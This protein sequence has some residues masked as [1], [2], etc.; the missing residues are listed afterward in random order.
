MKKLIFS[1]VVFS[2]LLIIGCQENFLTDPIQDTSMNDVQ[3]NSIPEYRQGTIVLKGVLANP[4][5]SM[6]EYYSL[7]GRISFKH[8]TVNNIQSS[9]QKNK[10]NVFLQLDIKAAISTS[11][12]KTARTYTVSGSTKDFVFVP[13]EGIKSL[14]KSFPVQGS[15]SRMNLVC[16]FEVTSDGV[17]L[18]SRWLEAPGVSITDAQ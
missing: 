13:E 16:L 11:G 10:Y 8:Q 5:V 12:D 3:K 9:T 7:E 6:I 14:R 4:N 2:G 18:L 15:K 17:N 1:L